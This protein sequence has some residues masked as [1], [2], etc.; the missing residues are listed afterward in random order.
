MA[1]QGKQALLTGKCMEVCF[2]LV[3]TRVNVCRLIK[4]EDAGCYQQC[5]TDPPQRLKIDPGVNLLL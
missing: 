4:T 5:K 1:T 2:V 3:A